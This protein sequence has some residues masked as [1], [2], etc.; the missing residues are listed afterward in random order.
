MDFTNHI[1][2]LERKNGFSSEPVVM[3]Q[4]TTETGATVAVC[5]GNFTAIDSDVIV[6]FVP[7]HVNEY[8]S[9]VLSAIVNRGGIRLKQD[10]LHALEQSD[11]DSIFQAS[12]GE[13]L[14]AEVFHVV[15]PHW[16]N[17]EKSITLLIDNALAK[18]LDKVVNLSCSK[19]IFTPLTAH[20]LGYPA[21]FYSD[22]LLA[23]LLNVPSTLEIII[24]I[25]DFTG[26]SLFDESMKKYLMTPLTTQLAQ[27][28]K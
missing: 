4:G 10:L 21:E 9:P 19:I 16:I 25:E 2:D 7:H 18:V 20:P 6:N 1:I 8:T 15:V 5:H 17:G 23:A 11:V 13:L 26:Y 27:L 28:H 3:L 22:R 14:C 12:P 24:V